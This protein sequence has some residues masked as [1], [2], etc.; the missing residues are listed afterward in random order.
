MYLLKTCIINTSDTL[1]TGRLPASII[2]RLVMKLQQLV[3]LPTL[4]PVNGV[5]HSADDDS[6]PFAPWPFWQDNRVLSAAVNERQE[7]DCR[8][9]VW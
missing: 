9:R 2:S 7:Q 1:Y 6:V 5:T 3:L 4:F 8:R